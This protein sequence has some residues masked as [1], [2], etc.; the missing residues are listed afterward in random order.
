MNLF[1]EDIDNRI[2]DKFGVTDEKR[3]NVLGENL[4]HLYK[5]G[6]IN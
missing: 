3:D 1:I 4:G 5:T 2:L 6:K